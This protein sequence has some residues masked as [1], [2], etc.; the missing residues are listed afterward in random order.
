MTVVDPDA[1]FDDFEAAAF[2]NVSI[3]QLRRWRSERRLAYIKAGRSVRYMRSDLVAF[4]ESQRVE[5]VGEHPMLVRRFP[6]AS[7]GRR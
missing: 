5:P 3:R 6:A 2:L 7:G 4:A 1:L